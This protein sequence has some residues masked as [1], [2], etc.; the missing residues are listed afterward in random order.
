[1]VGICIGSAWD[2]VL[3]CDGSVHRRSDISEDFCF[4]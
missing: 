4:I 3:V 1:L 2:E